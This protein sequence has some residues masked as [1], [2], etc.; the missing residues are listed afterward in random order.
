MSKNL[1]GFSSIVNFTFRLKSFKVRNKYK[2]FEK[3]CFPD[4]YDTENIELVP[5]ERRS[6]SIV[7]FPKIYILNYIFFFV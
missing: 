4:I 7:L 3:N 5:S 2:I 6:S 1:S